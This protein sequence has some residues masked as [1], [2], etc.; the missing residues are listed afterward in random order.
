[1]NSIRSNSLSLKYQW[2]TPSNIEIRKLIRVCGKNSVPLKQTIKHRISFFIAINKRKS[3]EHI[4]QI[5]FNILTPD[6]W[7][8]I[9]LMV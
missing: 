6:Y 2:F 7:F 4:T 5:L 8:P 3:V 1:M 9:R